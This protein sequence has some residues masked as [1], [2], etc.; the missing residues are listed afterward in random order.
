L[1]AFADYPVPVRLSHAD[2]SA[3]H[4]RRGIDYTASV[5]AYV[6]DRL[7]GFIFNGVD[8]WHGRKTAYDGGTGMLPDWRGQGILK[9][10]IAFSKNR[11]H[12]LGCRQW[13]LEVLQDNVKAV[14]AYEHAGFRKT[15]ELY[16]FERNGSQV[17]TG[18][19]RT[20]GR[21]LRPRT[22]RGG[23]QAAWT[24]SSC[25]LPEALPDHGW[26][27]WLPSWQNSE[28]SI[29]RSPEPMYCFRAIASEQKIGTIIA[30]AGGSIC[31]LAV[32]PEFRR[33]GVG[34]T[35]L[36]ILAGD[37]PEVKIRYV[38]ID[39]SDSGHL[40]FMLSAGFR[41]SARQWEMLADL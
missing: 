14:A 10:L 18:D 27:E 30:T 19:N 5:G 8:D 9:Q 31:Q 13:L 17:G 15:R 2:F 39:G 33:Q 21:G 24:I 25:S 26:L 4:R 22:S 32:A 7:V 3:M 34:N 41:E 11:L 6:D 23:K 36:A 40:A 35:L 12:E 1:E 28:A 29:L 38:N 16:C 20:I 37:D